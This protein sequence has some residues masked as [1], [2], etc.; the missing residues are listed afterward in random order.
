[1]KPVIKLTTDQRVYSLVGWLKTCLQKS[2]S[3]VKL[4]YPTEPTS[5]I[6]RATTCRAKLFNPSHGELVG[7][8]NS[9]HSHWLRIRRH[10]HVF[11][12][13]D[14]RSVRPF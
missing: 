3:P 8:V 5:R 6:K 13:A 9:D 1:M 7:D 11:L 2:R 12:A 4:A 14:E 10:V